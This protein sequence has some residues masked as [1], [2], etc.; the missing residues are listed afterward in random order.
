ME[1]FERDQD[2]ATGK[3]AGYWSRLGFE[4]LAD[5]PYWAMNLAYGRPSRSDLGLV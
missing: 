5:S 2:A 3:L 4:R 1:G